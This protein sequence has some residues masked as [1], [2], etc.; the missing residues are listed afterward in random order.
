MVA[1]SNCP[2]FTGLGPLQMP[3]LSGVPPRPVI[4]PVDGLVAQSVS[5]PSVPGSGGVL[6][7]T[8]TVLLALVQGGGTLMVS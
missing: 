4:R 3:P 2:P 7:V 8:V 1:G 6:S 5:A